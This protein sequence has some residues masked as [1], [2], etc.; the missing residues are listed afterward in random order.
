MATARRNSTPSSVGPRRSCPASACRSPT[1]PTWLHPGGY[2]WE[3]LDTELKYN[4]LC[5]PITSSWPRSGSTSIWG[6][7][8]TGSA[9]T[10]F[11]TYS[12][13]L[14]IGKGFGDLPAS[15]NILRP[16]AITA[17]LSSSVPGQAW[18]AEAR[19]RRRSITASPSNTACPSTIRTSARSTTTFF[20]HLIPLTEVNF[21]T[22]IS[23]YGAGPQVTTGSVQPGVDLHGRHLAVR[24]GGGRPDQQRERPRRRRRRRAAFLL[25]RHLPRFA[26]QTDLRR[27]QEEN[28][29]ASRHRK[30]RRR[31][32][33]SARAFRGIRPC[34]TRRSDARRG[35]NGRLAERNPPQ[36]QR[37]GGSR[38]SPPSR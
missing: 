25:R 3:A 38:I 28:D 11:N 37:R 35:R 6:R 5:I 22:P 36:I 14:D 12:P 29:H 17:E 21:S 27:L 8:G 24:A 16:F 19:T 1:A 2:G 23:N 7:T 13:V 32:R 26:R 33:V 34:A 10:P 15:L 9:Y 18:T 4:F 31:P 30:N 20:R